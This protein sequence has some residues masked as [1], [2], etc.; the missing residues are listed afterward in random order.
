MPA[1]EVAVVRTGTANLAS[2]RAAL[3][4]AGAIP[5]PVEKP[6]DVERAARLVLPGVGTLRAAMERLAADDLVSPLRDRLL[7]GE[8]TLAICLGMQI[9]CAGSEESSGVAGLGVVPGIATRFVPA[10]DR[11]VPQLG[12]NRIEPTLGARLLRAGHV[13]FANSFRL[14]QVPAGWAG[15]LADFGGD[16][17]AALERGAVLACQFH[18]ELSGRFGGQLIR[19]W[20]DAD[21]APEEE[22]C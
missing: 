3:H 7:A 22:P 6:R 9:L 19:R 5:V 2:V 17:A 12:W 20:L 1:L 14:E 11:R 15:A 8:P 10:P 21:R 4:R 16:F 18:P 13:Y